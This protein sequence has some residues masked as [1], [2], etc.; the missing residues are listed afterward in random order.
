MQIKAITKTDAR[1]ILESAKNF[2]ERIADYLKEN[3]FFRL[4]GEM[5]KRT[6]IVTKEEGGVTIPNIGS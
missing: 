3:N 5:D 1:K 6:K 2:A 4:K